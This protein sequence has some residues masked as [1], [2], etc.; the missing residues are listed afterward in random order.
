MLYLFSNEEGFSINYKLMISILNIEKVEENSV[1]VHL[2][3]F[4]GQTDN[5]TKSFF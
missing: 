5:P 4:E 1:R 2:G 3:D